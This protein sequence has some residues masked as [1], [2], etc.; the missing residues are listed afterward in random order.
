M[1][2]YTITCP[3][4]Q[5]MLQVDESYAGVSVQCPGC[6]QTFT[7]D[8]S[9]GNVVPAMVGIPCGGT[10]LNISFRDG[11][12]LEKLFL[13]WWICGLAVFVTCCISAIPFTVL[14]VIML[15]YFWKFLPVGETEIT[16][17]KAIGFLFIPFFNWYWAFVAYWR[18]SQHYERYGLASSG[19]VLGLLMP[20]LICV[21]AV[22]SI[23]HTITQNEI[24]LILNY[25]INLVLLV[26]QIIW[27]VMMRG[28]VKR[29]PKY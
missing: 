9:Y 27:F 2:D 15:Y 16:P 5:Q 20:I 6:L 7:V 28:V 11:A 14:E 8:L 4:C 10:G 17:G 26:I 21:G 3:Y 25:A 19:V 24:A 18:L 22:I 12:V 1:A 13:A 23:T 29:A